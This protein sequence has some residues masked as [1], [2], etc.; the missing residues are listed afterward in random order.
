LLEI[1]K[2]RA[3]NFLRLE[4]MQY[5]EQQETLLLPSEADVQ[6]LQRYESSLQRAFFQTLHELQRV[7]SMRLGKPAPLAAA[8]DVTL[9][10]ENGF[11][12]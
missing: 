12:S 2:E 1:L 4:E 3:T 6:R 8:L 7:Q 10:N 11:F 5:R 9:N